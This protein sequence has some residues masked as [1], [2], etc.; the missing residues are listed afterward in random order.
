M[1]GLGGEKKHLQHNI[2][3]LFIDIPTIPDNKAFTVNR[4]K[5][6]HTHIHTREANGSADCSL[7]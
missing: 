5:H 6:T 4:H 1:K 7:W 3:E 2:V